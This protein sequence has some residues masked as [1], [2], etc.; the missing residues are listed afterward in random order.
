MLNGVNVNYIIVLLVSGA[1]LLAAIYHTILF[2]HR[3]TALLGSYSAYLWATFSYCLLRSVYF[4]GTGGAFSYFNADEV[5]QMIAFA[6]Y[7]RFASVALELDKKTVPNAWLFAQMT[8][9][10]IL[11]YILFNTYLTNFGESNTVYLIA[12]ISI[13]CYLLIFGLFLLLTVIGKRPSPF[14]HYLFAGAVS[15]IFF[16]LISSVMNVVAPGAFLLG[17]ISWLM[18]GFFTD[19]VFFSAAIG[20]RIRQEYKEKE[21]SLTQLMQKEAELQQKEMEKLKAVYETREEERMRIARDLHDDMGSTLSSISIYGKVVHSY[22]NTDRKKA[23][24]FLNKIE[25]ASQMLQEHTHD[26]IWSLQTN[27]GETES[28]FKRMKKTAVELLSSAN[29]TPVTEIDETVLPSLNIGAQK[30]CWLIFKEAINNVCK[31]SKASACTVKIHQSGDSLEMLI[32][33]DGIGFQRPVSGNGLNNMMT[34][35]REIGG[36]CMVEG[37][38][39]HGTLVKVLLP[40]KQLVTSEENSQ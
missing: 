4:A 11:T 28:I 25:D 15:M 14:Y 23:E 10:L 1:V 38:P 22:L 24:D 19:V 37:C 9:Y 16:G 32:M 26:L 7:V 17:A 3:R 34:R 29:I 18:F 5:V 31:Y 36:E 27:Y 21:I 2:A 33:D 30:D 8:P 39:G 35:A 12:K 6:F 13:R 20:Y 40:V